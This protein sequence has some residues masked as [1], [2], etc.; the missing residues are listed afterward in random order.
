M[1]SAVCGV[2][3]AMSSHFQKSV[4]VVPSFGLH[5][6]SLGLSGGGPGDLHT[7]TYL[8]PN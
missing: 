2:S 6:Q 5:V 8:M 4:I 3:V 1:L 7:W